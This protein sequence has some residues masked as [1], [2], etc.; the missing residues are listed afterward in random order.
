MSVIV[1][2]VIIIILIVIAI[3]ITNNLLQTHIDEGCHPHTAATAAR[4]RPRT[5]VAVHWT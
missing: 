4:T 5:I 2:I 3:S 1:I